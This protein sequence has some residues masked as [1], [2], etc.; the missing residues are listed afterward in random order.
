MGQLK[1]CAESLEKEVLLPAGF[2]LVAPLANLE[3]MNSSARMMKLGPSRLDA[4]KVSVS[5]M[6]MW[7]MRIHLPLEAGPERPAL[8]LVIMS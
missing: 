3:A 5:T 1:C 4:Q 8:A 6:M 2:L 7:K